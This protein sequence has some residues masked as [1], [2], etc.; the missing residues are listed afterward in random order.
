MFLILE[1]SGNL[2]MEKQNPKM[3]ANISKIVLCTSTYYPIVEITNELKGEELKKIKLA[4]E[5]SILRMQLALD[6]FRNV[7]KVGATCVLTDGGSNKEFFDEIN[8]INSEANR[9]VIRVIPETS[10]KEKMSMGESRRLAFFSVFGGTIDEWNSGKRDVS[11]KEGAEFCLWIEP[12]KADLVTQE[13]LEKIL[14]TFTEQ[15][16]EI[17]VPARMQE[18]WETLPQKQAWIEK[19]ANREA[20]K[21]VG[22]QN[23]DLWFGPKV[24]SRAA[25]RF[26][27]ESKGP[28][29]EGLMEPV[30]RGIREGIA[31]V[32]AS[33]NYK[34]DLR[35]KEMEEG[36]LGDDF[37]SKR[38]TQYAEIQAFLG[39]DIW[40]QIGDEFRG[41][42]SKKERK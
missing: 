37:F 38:V 35:Q 11:D 3:S 36:D 28:R 17:V 29:W 23:L 4:N 1:L 22:S 15:N 6:T 27:L 39:N 12:E 9:E 21:I 18:G 25:A 41:S 32:P 19:R 2:R 34:Y 42:R 16:A 26:F 31:V 10:A 14:L 13:N 5:T 30:H 40:K 8:K 20:A 7:A 24:F 33:V